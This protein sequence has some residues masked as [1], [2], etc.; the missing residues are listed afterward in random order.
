MLRQSLAECVGTFVLV[1][2]GCGAAC[3]HQ[4][5]P[6]VLG[7]LGIALAF[8]L[9]VTTMIYAVGDV[10]GAHLNPAVTIAFI[11]SGRLDLRTGALFTLTQSIGA[12]GA[13][14]LLNVVYAGQATDLGTTAFAI[15]PGAAFA[16]EAVCTMILMFVIL[17]VATG[18]KEKGMMAGVAIG[19]A[20]GMNAVWAGP[21]TG[22][23]MNPARSL[24]PA[25][26]HGQL[27]QLSLYLLAP[28]VGAAAA[29]FLCR[30]VHEP[31]HCC[32]QGGGCGPSST[33]PK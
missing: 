26:I 20:V 23:S 31:G 8:G 12:I 17:A 29:V 10:S 9:A 24:G 32:I 21:L 18:A 6:T 16:V 25:L 14:S 7:Q 30:T 1:L 28:V 5:D 15:A 13:A 2:V 22:A 33:D 11:L 4:V 27:D 3:V 19:A